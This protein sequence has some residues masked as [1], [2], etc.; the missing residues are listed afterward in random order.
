MIRIP[1]R[2]SRI[3]WIESEA[4]TVPNPDPYKI[5]LL[6]KEFCINGKKS[7]G[8]D[9]NFPKTAIGGRVVT[10]ASYVA[11]AASASS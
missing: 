3:A 6:Q 4:T 10:F 9:R 5:V 8:G 7:A 1:N 11:F 2:P